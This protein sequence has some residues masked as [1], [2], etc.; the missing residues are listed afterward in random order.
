MDLKWNGR[1][2][3]DPNSVLRKEGEMGYEIWKGG[4]GRMHKTC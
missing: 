3:E 4:M 1:K 2:S